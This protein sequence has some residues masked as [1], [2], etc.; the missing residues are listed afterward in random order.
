MSIQ[1]E[2]LYTGVPTLFIRTAGCDLRC[3]WCDTPYALLENQGTDWS[4][5]ALMDEA[6]RHHVNNVC[7]TGGDPLRQREE[8]ITLIQKMLEKG[9][10]V[11]L[12]TSGAYPIDGLPND[13]R[14]VISMD[15]KL[16][17]SGMSR[18]NLYSNIALL[19]QWDQLKFIIADL[20]DYKF[21]K[22]VMQKYSAPC[23]IIMTPVGGKELRWLADKV[24]ED[25]L[26]V[27]V[28]P[29][30]HKYIWGDERGR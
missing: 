9:Y 26:Q 7:L 3:R 25:E 21:A 27:R 22:E 12:E 14:L 18:K 4:V 2:G 6:L 28:L 8:S 24:L 20:Q 13:R 16:P 17:G 23:E 11:V 1:G 30:L 29:Q 19:R 5:D 10:T 15:I